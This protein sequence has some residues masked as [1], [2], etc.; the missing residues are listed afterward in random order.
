MTSRLLNISKFTSESR[1]APTLPSMAAKSRE[2]APGNK[3]LISKE[4]KKKTKVVSH[5]GA[6]T[7]NQE[8]HEKGQYLLQILS[9]NFHTQNLHLQAFFHIH[10]AHPSLD[11]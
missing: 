7:Q 5:F 8:E 4:K 9:L 3:I 11:V 6:K 10:R 2:N 1:S